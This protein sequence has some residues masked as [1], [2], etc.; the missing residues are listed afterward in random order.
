MS[1][2][3]GK[4]VRYT[5]EEDAIMR[6]IWTS[7]VAIKTLL[8]QL[9]G[10]SFAS[11]VTRACSLGLGRRPKMTRGC[12]YVPIHA[13]ALQQLRRGP[14]RHAQIMLATGYSLSAV[15][16]WTKRMHASGEIHIVRR[17]RNLGKGCRQTSVWALGPGI[18]AP[19]LPPTPDRRRPVRAPKVDMF[20]TLTAR[21]LVGLDVP[22]G[23]MVAA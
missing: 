16:A 11:V 23:A 3:G 13:L 6:E 17:H 18:D 14:M 21:P 19:L 15:S 2:K 10:R 12:R 22:F 20:A 7:T 9:P 8:H 4:A 5:A 1:N